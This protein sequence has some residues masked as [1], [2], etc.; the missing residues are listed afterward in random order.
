MAGHAKFIR[1]FSVSRSSPLNFIIKIQFI[2]VKSS[3]LGVTMSALWLFSSCLKLLKSIGNHFKSDNNN[4]IGK[5]LNWKSV[6]DICQRIKTKCL[7]EARSRGY[8]VF[9][10]EYITFARSNLRIKCWMI[11][12]FSISFHCR[13]IVIESVQF[14]IDYNKSV[15]IFCHCYE[16]WET[17]ETV[18]RSLCHFSIWLCE[19]FFNSHW[20][21]GYSMKSAKVP[22]ITLFIGKKRWKVKLC[23]RII[24][25]PQICVSL[26]CRKFLKRLREWNVIEN[27]KRKYFL[28]IEHLHHYTLL[29]SERKIIKIFVVKW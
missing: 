7:A 27:G 15:R 25:P 14:T 1:Y 3:W 10:H 12:R 18:V 21:N 4:N 19:I 17:K 8:V 9:R 5:K 11:S 24:F 26:N 29:L 2:N 22:C 23:E 6:S 20:M 13:N 16:L 28:K